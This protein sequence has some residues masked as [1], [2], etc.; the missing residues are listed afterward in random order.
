MLRLALAVCLG[1][2]GPAVAQD[3][4]LLET[5]RRI[6][7]SLQKISFEDAREYCG[8]IGITAEGLLV[9]SKPRRGGQNGCRPRDPRGVVRVVASFH[10]HA[11]YEP[12]A[13]AELPSVQDVLSDMDE[14][15]DGFLTTPGGRFWY[16]DG[17]TGDSRLIC[18]PFCVP[19]D[20]RFQVGGWGPILPNY[21]LD[22][23]DAR[24]SQWDQEPRRLH[25]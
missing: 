25:R 9:S 20:P 15:V 24:A 8:T 6:L 11:A 7:V 3:A 22:E 12:R 17:R 21:T 23:L 1:V 4:A 19:Y 14:G 13:D 5:A 10:T 2:A 18:G 16:I